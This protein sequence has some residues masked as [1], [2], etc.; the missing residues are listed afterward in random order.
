MI[1]SQGAH[2]SDLGG[3]FNP[4]PDLKTDTPSLV[5]ARAFEIATLTQWV[6]DFHKERLAAKKDV[7]ANIAHR[8]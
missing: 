3:P 7:T 8:F 5:A 2:H 4:V 1:I 6:A